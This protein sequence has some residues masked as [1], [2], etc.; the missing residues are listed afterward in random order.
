MT[1]LKH[2]ILQAAMAC[3][4]KLLGL[5]FIR[6]LVKKIVIIY[7]MSYCFRSSSLL[8]INLV[9]NSLDNCI[10]LAQNKARSLLYFLGKAKVYVL[11]INLYFLKLFFR[12][13]TFY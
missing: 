10:I 2:Q 12:N 6:Y 4:N 8:K 11:A 1:Q 7:K 5:F 13:T 3:R 9:F